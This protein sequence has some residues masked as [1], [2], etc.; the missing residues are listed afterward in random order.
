[1]GIATDLLKDKYFNGDVSLKLG[2]AAGRPSL[3][4]ENLSVN[5]TAIPEMFMSEMRNQNLL[6]E[7]MKNP[8]AAKLFEGIE[9]IRIENGELLIVPKAAP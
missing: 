3:Y 6:E 4:L 9:E 5:G 1:E 8:D 2:M 7:A